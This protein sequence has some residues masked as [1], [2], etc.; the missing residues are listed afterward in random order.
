V[1]KPGGSGYQHGMAD[2]TLPLAPPVLLPLGDQ[3]L[4]IRF[5]ASLSDEANRAAIAFARRLVEALP[6]GVSEIDPNLVSVLLKYDP[7]QVSY[8]RLAGEVRLLLNGGEAMGAAPATRHTIPARF[9]GEDI[10]TVAAKLNLTPA[11]FVREHC[12]RPLR[13]LTTGFAPGFVYCG[14]HPEAL[15]VPRREAVR[16]QV[17][18]GTLLF[19]ARQTAMASTPI[20]TGWHVIGHTDFSNFDPTADPPT[21]LREGDEIMFEAVS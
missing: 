15:E 2:A 18:A 7:A 16:R 8:E 1:V 17:P 13:V 4:L 9:D 6:L 10:E 3:G 14:F 20:P 21:T 11:A 5:A 19:A 12:A